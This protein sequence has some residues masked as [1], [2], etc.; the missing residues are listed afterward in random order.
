[1]LYFTS[2]EH[3]GSDRHIMLSKRPFL[4]KVPYTEEDMEMCRF[5]KKYIPDVDAMDD[6]IV[7]CHNQI[8]E[9]CDVVM[10]VG[11]FGDFKILPK[12]NGFHY[13]ILGNYEQDILKK[14]F[15]D[16][17]DS[18]KE[19]LKNVGFVNVYRN[20]TTSIYDSKN[21]DSS[22]PFSNVF[23]THKPEEC[24]KDGNTMNIFGHIHEKC[25][26]K[27]YGVNCGVDANHFY[28]MSTDDIYFYFNAIKNHYDNNVFI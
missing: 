8:V 4:K 22:I 6:Y 14:D 17:Y 5:S 2:D 19:Y 10:H 24:I 12:L 11:D 16:D 1:M 27:R 28:P 26:I 18:F 7:K 23:I 13:L 15:D 9:S 25:K 3:Y 21:I 20:F